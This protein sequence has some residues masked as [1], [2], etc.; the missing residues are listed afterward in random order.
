MVHAYNEICMGIP[1]TKKYKA[2]IEA[3][4]RMDMEVGVGGSDHFTDRGFPLG[5][6]KMFWKSVDSG[7]GSTTL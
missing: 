1:S 4:T 3:A 7:D 6:M 2:L 5:G